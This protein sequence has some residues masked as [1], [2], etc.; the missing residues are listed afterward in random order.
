MRHLI[1]MRTARRSDRS[2]RRRPTALATAWLFALQLLL[3]ALG[4]LLPVSAAAAA[5]LPVPICADGHLSWVDP[6]ALPDQA[7]KPAKQDLEGCTKCCPHWPGGVLLPPPLHMVQRSGQPVEPVVLPR[8]PVRVG[9]STAPPPP[10]RA[11][12]SSIA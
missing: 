12:P 5:S 3:A 9:W 11:P 10:A 4:P 8:Q 7:P 6:A 1:G 2:A